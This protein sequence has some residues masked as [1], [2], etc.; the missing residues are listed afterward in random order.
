MTD[1]TSL[2]DNNFPSLS[3]FVHLTGYRASNIAILTCA[4]DRSK[5]F[6]SECLESRLAVLETFY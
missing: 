4:L 1:L 3:L 2:Q 6:F 5:D